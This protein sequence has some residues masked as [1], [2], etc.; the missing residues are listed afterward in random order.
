M[1][2]FNF[3]KQT[4][5]ESS[6]NIERKGFSLLSTKN[7]NV[8]ICI[9]FLSSFSLNTGKSLKEVPASPAAVQVCVLHRL[10][11]H[12]KVSVCWLVIRTRAE[13]VNVVDESLATKLTNFPS[14]FL[15][16]RKMQHIFTFFT[17]FSSVS[18]IAS[19]HCMKYC[20]FLTAHSF[21]KVRTASSSLLNSNSSCFLFLFQSEK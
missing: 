19:D 13:A 17:K 21:L 6:A 11:S 5:D 7:A 2:L 20:W 12:W 4:S 14:L 18:H 10:Y 3:F 15:S 8:C 1:L 9:R 16:N